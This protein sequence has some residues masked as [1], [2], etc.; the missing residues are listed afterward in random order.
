M[1]GEKPG[2]E[3]KGLR[4][5]IVPDREISAVDFRRKRELGGDHAFGKAGR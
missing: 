2:L 4:G 3:L 5:A 1:K